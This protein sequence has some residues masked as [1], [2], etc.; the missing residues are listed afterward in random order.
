MIV[1]KLLHFLMAF[2]YPL[3]ILMNGMEKSLKDFW[4]LP[5]EKP[6]SD[7]NWAFTFLEY[8]ERSNTAAPSAIPASSLVF[9]E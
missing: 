5:R 6:N 7:M 8:L 4:F 9:L 1:N 3:K 2:F